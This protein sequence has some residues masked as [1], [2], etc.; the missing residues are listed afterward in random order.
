MTIKLFKGRALDDFERKL[1]GFGVFLSPSRRLHTD[2]LETMVQYLQRLSQIGREVIVDF[3]P[4]R[5]FDHFSTVYAR[6][7]FLYIGRYVFGEEDIQ[8]DFLKVKPEAL[9]MVGSTKDKQYNRL[10]V[11]ALPFSPLAIAEQVEEVDQDGFQCY[12]DFGEEIRPL[13]RREQYH[14]ITALC[15]G[16][17]VLFH[18][19]GSAFAHDLR[20][21]YF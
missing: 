16:G 21:V 19:K 2:N 12:H 5:H 10:F 17:N 6:G 9:Y 13:Y 7:E 4:T 11:K 15:P 3:S 8:S 1:T 14:G 20:E 18:P